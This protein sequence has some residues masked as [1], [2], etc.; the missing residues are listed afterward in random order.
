MEKKSDQEK[1]N[2]AIYYHTKK[3]NGHVFKEWLDW[4]RYRKDRQASKN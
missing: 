3:L 1:L 2:K 4:L